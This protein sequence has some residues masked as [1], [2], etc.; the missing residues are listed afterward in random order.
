MNAKK[1]TR[2][3]CNYGPPYTNRDGKV[4]QRKIHQE[5][6]SN[7]NYV[8]VDDESTHA[9]DSRQT[10]FTVYTKNGEYAEELDVA[11]DSYR[12]R[13]PRTVAKKI[14]EAVLASGSYEPGLKIATVIERR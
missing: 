1:A 9:K 4:S 10:V 12:Y 14:A 5:N 7:Q 11:V 2:F 6:T 13:S 3:V 8:I